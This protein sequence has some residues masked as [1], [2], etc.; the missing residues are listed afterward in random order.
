MREALTQAVS[1]NVHRSG[2]KDGE[3][4]ERDARLEH[5]QNFCPAGKHRNIR[6]RER[7]AGVEGEKQVIDE[8]GRPEILSH[9]LA[10]L[11]VQYHLGKQKRAIVWE[12][13]EARWCGPPASSRQY[14][15]AKTNRLQ[16]QRTTAERNRLSRS[17]LIPG[18]R[19]M[20]RARD[21]VTDRVTMAVAAYPR[22]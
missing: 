14:Q 6:G 19:D 1:E 17:V 4:G 7:R 2:R 11:R 8:S 10:K 20:S 16:T 3:S 9:L 13:R 5:H 22:A 12:R 15:Q 18:R 21:R